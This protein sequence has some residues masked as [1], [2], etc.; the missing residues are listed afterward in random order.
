MGQKPIVIT[1]NGETKSLREWAESSGV[2]HVTLD[3]RIR[4]GVPFERAI[5]PN[6]LKQKNGD[7]YKK[8]SSGTPGKSKYEH[9][10]IVEKA[11]GRRL[12]STARIHHVDENR[13]NNSPSN[14]VVCPND[15]Y[16]RLLHL[17][18][19]ALNASGNANFRKCTHCQKWDDPSNLK[20]YGQQVVHGKCHNRYFNERRRAEREKNPKTPKS[21]AGENNPAAKLKPDDVR[22]IRT[23][24]ASGMSM[25][26]TARQVGVSPPTVKDIIAGKRWSNI[27]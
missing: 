6:S 4:N 22:K 14:L 17:R 3:R 10:A 11:I 2:K 9:Q 13:L 24:V 25:S 20:F 1:H 23:L 27:L 15:A 12:P 26:A 8:V 19:E 7:W 5:K 21:M 16:H 18:T